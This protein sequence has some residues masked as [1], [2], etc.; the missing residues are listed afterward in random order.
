[1]MDSFNSFVINI[2]IP[3]KRFIFSSFTQEIK[4]KKVI[5]ELVQQKSDELVQYF[6]SNQIAMLKYLNKVMHCRLQV[7]SRILDTIYIIGER[8]G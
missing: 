3:L 1:M 4:K 6:D 8:S 2:V 5:V 7:T